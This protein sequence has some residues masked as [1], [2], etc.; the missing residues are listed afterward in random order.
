MATKVTFSVDEETVR[1]LRTAAERLRKPQ[2]QV[3]R[4]AIAEYAARIGRLSEGERVSLLGAFDRLVPTLPSRAASAVDA[5]LAE[6]RA[7][8]RQSGRRSRAR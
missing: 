6:L 3:V 7:A 8:R 1:S 4:E 5:E 2:S